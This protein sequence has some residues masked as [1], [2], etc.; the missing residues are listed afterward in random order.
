MATLAS[1][2]ASLPLAPADNDEELF[3]VVSPEN[4]PLTTA[5]RSV[6]HRDGLLHRAAHVLLFRY[7]GG[8]GGG[9]EMLMQ[10][11]S[12]RKRV[13][14]SRLDLSAAEHVSAGEGAIAA[15]T[16]GLREE[17]G[18]DVAAERLVEVRPPLVRRIVYPDVAVID[19]EV[20]T[21][22]ALEWKGEDVDGKVVADEAEVAEVMWM[23]VGDVIALGTEKPGELTPWLCEEMRRT[24]LVITAKLVLDCHVVDINL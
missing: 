12:S 6:C 18:L 11:R 4:V 23:K 10:R 19:H 8:G 2:T 24:D 14:P 1:A 13:A 5:T 16:R 7:S 15:S 17:L 9:A 21:L 22:H 20:V 3:D